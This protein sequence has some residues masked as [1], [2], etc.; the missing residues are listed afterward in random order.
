MFTK[1][2][3]RPLRSW[4]Y[5]LPVVEEAGEFIHSSKFHRSASCKLYPYDY[6]M[7]TEAYAEYHVWS[8]FKKG[9]IGLKGRSLWYEGTHA[10]WWLGIK[11]TENE[12]RHL[13]VVLKMK[14]NRAVEYWGQCWSQTQKSLA[15]AWFLK[16]LWLSTSSLTSLKA[17]F[18]CLE[19]RS[20]VPKI[21]EQVNG[22]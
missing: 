17:S 9:W 16:E 1:E 6:V 5:Q 20:L 18:P 10:P 19:T 7:K 8:Q 13:Y 22:P 14:R 4:D 15:W 21:L 3:N 2:K 12:E 11:S